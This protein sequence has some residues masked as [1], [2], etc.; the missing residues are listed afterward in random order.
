MEVIKSNKFEPFISLQSVF[1]PICFQINMG[2]K[3]EN[4]NQSSPIKVTILDILRCTL[5]AK[6]SND[7]F[8]ACTKEYILRK[9]NH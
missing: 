1:I 2:I 5:S 3:K 9:Q 8:Q 6:Y 7:V 4:M